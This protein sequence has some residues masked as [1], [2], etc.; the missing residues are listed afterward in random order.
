MVN[1]WFNSVGKLLLKNTYSSIS[2]VTVVLVS[3]C[4][5]LWKQREEGYWASGRASDGLVSSMAITV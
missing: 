2:F 1:V 4:L 5:M 3:E